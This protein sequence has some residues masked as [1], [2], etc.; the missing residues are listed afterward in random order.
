M[1]LPSLLTPADLAA[2]CQAR[3]DTRLLDVRTPGEFAGVHL[4][5][6]FNVPLDALGE[7]ADALHGAHPAPVVLLCQSGQRA[8]RA[9]AALR[10]AG[11]ADLH[12]LDGGVAGWG[13]AGLPVVRGRPRLSLERQVRIAAGA[14]AA[15]GAALALLVHPLFV[16]LPLVVGSGLVFA[17]VTDACLLGLLLARLP[18]NRAARCD[19]ERAVRALAAPPQLFAGPGSG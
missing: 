4:A 10:A 9:D 12:V 18:Y 8:R 5:G 13:A 19:V 14:L 3:P 11:L 7:H 2:L 16:L 15:T 1:S 6:S 17:G